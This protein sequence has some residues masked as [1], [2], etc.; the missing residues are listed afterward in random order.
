MFQC[1]QCHFIIRKV[2]VSNT[3]VLIYGHYSETCDQ[4]FIFIQFLSEI[5]L[6]FIISYISFHLSNLKVARCEGYQAD[7]ARRHEHGQDLVQQSPAEDEVD[8]HALVAVSV[9]PEMVAS[10]NYAVTL[11]K[12]LH[13]IH[14]PQVGQTV[15]DQLGRVSTV[16]LMLKC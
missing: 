1:V 15:L 13:E 8:L 11:D 14:R 3:I 6:T 4:R 7:G 10:V 9:A 16:A 5:T 12:V 2:T